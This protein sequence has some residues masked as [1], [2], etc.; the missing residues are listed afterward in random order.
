MDDVQVRYPVQGFD[1]FRKDLPRVWHMVLDIDRTFAVLEQRI[2]D[3]ITDTGAE[4]DAYAH[5]GD[6]DPQNFEAIDIY[7]DRATEYVNYAIELADYWENVQ[8]EVVDSEGVEDEAV[9]G[10]MRLYLSRDLPTTLALC[11]NQEPDAVVRFSPPLG[12]WIDFR[13]PGLGIASLHAQAFARYKDALQ[14][15]AMQVRCAQEG[16]YS[17][18]AYNVNLRAAQGGPVGPTRPTRPGDVLRAPP[19]AP[20]P[21]RL[22]PPPGGQAP[23]PA[24]APAP[25]DE[26]WSLGAK[27][28]VGLG[29][30]V[31]GGGL[32][33]WLGKQAKSA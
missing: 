3:T 11:N 8:L 25:A 4:L 26:G 22:P 19:P 17:L 21:T 33:W 31:V 10:W 24:P 15:A 5:S 16:L 1:V 6:V 27:I 14:K 30:A 9:D 28:A 18:V 12:G 32:Y 29:I 23:A 7:L 13:C 20:P 2:V